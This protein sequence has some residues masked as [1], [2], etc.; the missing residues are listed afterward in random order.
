MSIM[1]CYPDER[2]VENELGGKW[3]LFFE[4]T[5]DESGAVGLEWDVDENDNPLQLN[6]VLVV[7][8]QNGV[9]V[10]S[11]VSLNVI[12][13][14]VS[15]RVITFNN[16]TTNVENLKSWIGCTVNNGLIN[17]FGKQRNTITG[18]GSLNTGTNVIF[19]NSINYFNLAISTVPVGTNIKV[20]V[21]RGV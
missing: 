7:I 16:A 15:D 5:R 20:Y 8:T 21:L 12:S 10:Q 18:S 3:E 13:P 9:P 11:S 4:E 19:A 14:S 17:A 1:P 6:G 2:S